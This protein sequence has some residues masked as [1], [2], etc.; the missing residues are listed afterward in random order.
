MTSENAKPYCLITGASQGIGKAFALECASR[1]WNVA[2]VSL[3]GEKLP[4]FTAEIKAT[5]QVDAIYLEADLSHEQAAQTV[6]DWIQ[7]KQ[8]IVN[9]LIN[10]AGFGT[11]GPLVKSNH[12]VNLSMIRLNVMNT[13]SLTYLLLPMLLEQPKAW[14]INMSS[15]AGITPTPYKSLYAA[16]KVFIAWFTLGLQ[17]ELKDTNVKLSYVAPG[18]VVTNPKVQA[19]IDSAGWLSRKTAIYPDHLA[20]LAVNRALKGKVVTVPGLGGKIGYALARYLPSRLR[21]WI[22]EKPMSRDSGT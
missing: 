22:L 4:E 20:R 11:H 5:H 15:I 13:Y 3:P 12:A 17:K 18:G 19:R 2:L 9:F 10:N 6:M 16:T 21:L 7:Q 14:I 1:G 8:V